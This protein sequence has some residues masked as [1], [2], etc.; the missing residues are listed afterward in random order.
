MNWKQEKEGKADLPRT[1]DW[2][3]L[4]GD[5]SD[6]WPSASGTQGKVQGDVTGFQA[7]Q[8]TGSLL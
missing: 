2:S 4:E 8:P 3:V 7:T 6:V 5:T 1:G